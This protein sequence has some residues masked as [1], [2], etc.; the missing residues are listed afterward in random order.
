MV[1]QN[2]A[3]VK[4]RQLLIEKDIV[5]DAGDMYR[6]VRDDAGFQRRLVSSEGATS[7]TAFRLDNITK[8]GPGSRYDVNF[9]GRVYTPWREMVGHY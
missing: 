2:R 9:E 8:P 4:Y 5:S 6:Y 1:L 3:E 7:G